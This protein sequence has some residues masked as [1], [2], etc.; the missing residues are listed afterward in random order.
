MLIVTIGCAAYFPHF[1]V[2]ANSLPFHSLVACVMGVSVGLLNSTINPTTNSSTESEF[3]SPILRE[4]LDRPA[5]ASKNSFGKPH[6]VHDVQGSAPLVGVL[7]R[8]LVGTR[9]NRCRHALEKAVSQL[10]ISAAAGRSSRSIPSKPASLA[11]MA[12]CLNSTMIVVGQR[13]R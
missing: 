1:D 9:G 10:F 2:I 4:G 12:A 5:S 6:K 8:V 13:F 3:R 7:I 11:F